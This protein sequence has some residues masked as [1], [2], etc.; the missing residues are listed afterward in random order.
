MSDA[1]LMDAARE[2]LRI[3]LLVSLPLLLASLLVGLLVS[4][5]QV[6]T[7]IQD[8]TLTFVPKILGVG[9]VLI[10]VGPWMTRVLVD[11]TRQLLGVIQAMGGGTGGGIGG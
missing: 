4:L 1:M 11:F 2:A 7:S 5:A 6:A 3:A 8:A 9:A 10:F